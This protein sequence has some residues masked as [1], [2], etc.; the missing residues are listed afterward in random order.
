MNTTLIAYLEWNERESRVER[1]VQEF[2]IQRA[3]LF[4]RKL[5]NA[6]VIH[7]AVYEHTSNETDDRSQST[8]YVRPYSENEIPEHGEIIRS[9]I[10]EYCD[11]SS[12]GEIEFYHLLDGSARR[13]WKSAISTPLEAAEVLLDHYRFV[14]GG[15]YELVYSVLDTDRNKVLVFLVEE[16]T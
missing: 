8:V 11:I 5:V 2:Q 10:F 7:N 15:S 12:E 13:L 9:T 16:R 6:T 3:E 1:I 14:S 4:V